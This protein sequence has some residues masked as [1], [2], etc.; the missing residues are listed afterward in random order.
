LLPSCNS[1]YQIMGRKLCT[2]RHYCCLNRLAIIARCPEYTYWIL[3]KEKQ[4]GGSTVHCDVHV[5]NARCG[6]EE[7]EILCSTTR[8]E[9]RLMQ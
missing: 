5:S 1:D 6:F 4:V 2:K 8:Y 9:K 3:T 7:L